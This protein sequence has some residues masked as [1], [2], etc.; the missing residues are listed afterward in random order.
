[1]PTDVR[2][3]WR[4]R[5]DAGGTWSEVEALAMLTD[6]G[7][8]TV[9]SAVASTVGEAVAAA[10]RIGW[11]VA[12]KTAEV[13]HKSDVD[14]VRLGV[15]GPE[16]LRDGY[17]DLSARLGPRVTVA[18]MAPPGVELALGTVRDPQ[19]GPLVLVAVGGVLVEVLRDRRM[20]FPPLDEPRAGRLVDRLAARSLLDGV[21][22]R[23]PADVGAIVRALV[24]LSAL[25]VDLGDRIEAL[26]V[27]PLVC[28]P[29]GCL[30]VDAL[31]VPRP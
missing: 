3:R 16:E 30:A 21:R 17:R 18:S 6:Y 20:A 26:D 24:R 12:L 29:H 19:F 27:N 28:G 8:P 14:G 25:A 22:G 11:P 23:P 13:L 10:E 5:F 2:D 4:G 31:V 7:I 9:D 1:V 15:R